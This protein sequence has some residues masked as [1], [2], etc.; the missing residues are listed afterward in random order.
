MSTGTIL[1]IQRFCIHDG[2]GIRTVVFLKGCSLACRWCANPASQK[3]VIEPGYFSDRCQSCGQCAQA[4][5]IGAIV[6]DGRAPRI[7]RSLCDGCGACAKVCPARAIEML[8]VEVNTDNVVA[9]VQK[10]SVFYRNSGGGLT[11]SGGEPLMQPEFAGDIL[12][13]CR[14]LGIHTAVETSGCLPWANFEMVRQ[15]VELFLFDLKHPDD[16]EHRKA[17][18]QGNTRIIEN[19]SA[20]CRTGS[21]VILRVPVIPGYNDS[22]ARI[23]QLAELCLSVGQGIKQVELLPYHNLGAQ[24]YELLGKAYELYGLKTPS[25]EHLRRLAELL[26]ENMKHA[27]ISCHAIFGTT[28]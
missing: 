4:C 13:Q 24:K 10:D 11:L 27:G 23:G 18:G 7:D 26:D 15:S 2:P 16:A 25:K 21:H 14:E 19:L 6:F 1:N 17:T 3:P 22:Q 28:F 20:L 8:G 9:E 12:R 5:P